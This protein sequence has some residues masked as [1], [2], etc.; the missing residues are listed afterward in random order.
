MRCSLT[1]V[2]RDGLLDLVTGKRWWA[3]GPKGDVDAAGKPF[4]YAFLLRRDESRQVTFEPIALDDA[5]GIGTQ[6]DSA[7]VN[8]DGYADFVVAQ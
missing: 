3:H 5:S 2:D 6:F 8:A 7:D 1:D 4:V